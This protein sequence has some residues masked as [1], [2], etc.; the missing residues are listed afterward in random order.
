MK[1][2]IP[3]SY[4]TYVNY[5]SAHPNVKIFVSQCGIQSLQEAV[6]YAVPVLG[7]PFLQEQKLNAQKFILEGAG[8]SLDLAEI[9][10]QK[11]V[12]SIGKILQDER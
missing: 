6:Y 4:F 12:D 1:W 3:S 9:T 10:E 11:L 7:I 8:L 5:F 2:L